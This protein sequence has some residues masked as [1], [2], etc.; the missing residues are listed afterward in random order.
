V[1]LEARRNGFGTINALNPRRAAALTRFRGLRPTVQHRSSRV[2]R[3]VNW[4]E[5]SPATT[6]EPGRM[7]P[8][9]RRESQIGGRSPAGRPRGNHRLGADTDHSPTGTAQVASSPA[10]HDPSSCGG[11]TNAVATRVERHQRSRTRPRAITV[12]IISLVTPPCIASVV[13]RDGRRARG[14][15][16]KRIDQRDSSASVSAA[17]MHCSAIEPMSCQVRDSMR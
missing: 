11:H 13:A 8:E 1:P 16:R 7:P 14:T 15:P 17:V 12:G 2:F 10:T 3:Q 6:G 9:L 5:R 4:P